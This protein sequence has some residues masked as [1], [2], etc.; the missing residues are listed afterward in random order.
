MGKVGFRG[1]GRDV[2]VVVAVVAV[3]L[4]AGVLALTVVGA[5][6]SAQPPSQ[7][8]SP[9]QAVQTGQPSM[10]QPSQQKVKLRLVIPFSGREYPAFKPIVDEYQRR[11]PNVEIEVIFRSNPE[12]LQT[13]PQ[14]LAAGNPPGDVIS[15]N[16]PGFILELAQKGY[17]VDLTN[18]VKADEY[19]PTAIQAV[20]RDGK[21]WAAPFTMWIVPGFFYRK[22]FF[23]RDGLS[24]PRTWDEFLQLLDRLR[25]VP[26]VKAPL[27]TPGGGGGVRLS[28][29]LNAFVAAYGGYDLYLKLRSGEVKWDDPRVAAIV[30]QRLVPLIG[31]GYFS[32]EQV[33]WT[34]L[35]DM[36]LAGQ[37]PLFMLG[38][39]L[40]ARIDPANAS[41]VDVLVL[42]GAK[43][44]VG[45]LDYWIVPK[46]S[47][48]RE[49]ALDFVKF[50]S[51]YGQELHVSGPSGKLP[52]WL[53][54]P[55]DK[56]WPPMRGV[57]RK[58]IGAGLKPIVPSAVYV[59]PRDRQ[60]AMNQYASLL[61][62]SPDRWREVL[63]SL[64]REVQT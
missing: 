7:Q 17:L 15:L 36:W 13:L 46:D 35:P 23:E 14:Q 37:Y 24:E 59:I 61:F 28:D 38:T 1:I 6:P 49:V 57:Y 27:A 45:S 12:L 11:N 20:T 4:V 63:A 54:V 33:D 56:I 60:I 29:V 21:I 31:G 53:K 55:E 5:Q 40:L 19:V 16:S 48:N 44:V 18:V 32:P 2:L 52:T 8:Q 34:A 41:D 9:T 58:T 10:P 64:A 3:V 62:T 50:A 47:P 22:S 42:P 51:T 39:F 26:G 25:Q 30:E 43:A